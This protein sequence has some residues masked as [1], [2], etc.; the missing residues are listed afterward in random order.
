LKLLELLLGQQDRHGGVISFQ[1][2]GGEILGQVDILLR[3]EDV[4][5]LNHIF[6]TDHLGNCVGLDPYQEEGPPNPHHRGRGPYL[7]ILFLELQE[8]LG[9]DPDLSQVHLEGCGPLLF[10]GVEFKLIQVEVGLFPH[11]QDAAV[12]EFDAERGIGA[13]FDVVAQKNGH[14]HGHL[15]RAGH[16]LP[17]KGRRPPEPRHLADRVGGMGRQGEDKEQQGQGNP[18]AQGYSHN[19]CPHFCFHLG[20]L[21]KGFSH[22]DT[23]KQRC[24]QHMELDVLLFVGSVTLCDA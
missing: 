15:H 1:D 24:H 19:R 17:V 12:L 9:K 10:L 21:T 6:E 16:G 18:P 13:G 5:D 2:V 22:R 8:V 20:V 23:E 7:K 11:G 4:G 14:S 3:R